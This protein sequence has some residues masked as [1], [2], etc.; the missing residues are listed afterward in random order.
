[1]TDAFEGYVTVAG[2]SPSTWVTRIPAILLG[3][4]VKI[5][6]AMPIDSPAFVSFILEHI[7]NK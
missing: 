2:L 3:I 1:M 5:I 4:H 7:M 6:F